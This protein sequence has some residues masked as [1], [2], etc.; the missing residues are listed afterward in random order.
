MKVCFRQQKTEVGEEE[1][2][3]LWKTRPIHAMYTRRWREW[4]TL[5]KWFKKAGLKDSTEALSLKHQI[6]RGK[7][8]P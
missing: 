1:E 2:K 6:C 5:R 3:A 7:G 4:L 8:G